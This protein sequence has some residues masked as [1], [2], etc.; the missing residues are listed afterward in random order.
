MMIYVLYFIIWMSIGS[1]LR[2]LS[3][4]SV[5]SLS[6][7]SQCDIC[8]KVLSWK[9]LI[10]LFSRF[11]QRWKCMHCG[12]NISAEYP[13]YEWIVWW[14]FVLF[15]YIA[16]WYNITYHVY[17]LVLLSCLIFMAMYD[18]RFQL[19]HTKAYVLCIFLLF[20]L[21]YVLHLQGFEHLFSLAMSG[22]YVWWMS[23]VFWF[24]MWW[25]SFL[26]SYAFR[27]VIME[28]LWFGDVLFSAVL[29]FMAWVLYY[30]VF[31]AVVSWYASIMYVLLHALLSSILGIV[32]FFIGR[33]KREFA[34]IPY[35][36]LWFIIIAIAIVLKVDFP[37]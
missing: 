10:P 11:I 30:G 37:L 17:W 27:G 12:S 9:E 14:L 32:L 7:R 22:L 23:I 25:L 29:W 2:K 13:K 16:Q 3:D 24:V 18:I 35:M 6:H 20:I 5:L 8:H 36:L 19:L 28:W 21:F 1:F 26:I 15:Y 4:W 33:L 34:F 31:N